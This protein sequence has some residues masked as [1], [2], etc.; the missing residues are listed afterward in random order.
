MTQGKRKVQR[1]VDLSSYEARLVEKLHTD[2]KEMAKKRKAKIP[3]LQDV[4]AGAIRTGIHAV[5]GSDYLY[6]ELLS[7]ET[8][9]ELMV[10]GGEL[11]PKEDE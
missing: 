8:M 7:E 2:L 4:L 9:R 6:T 11:A 1:F 3:T 10:S 5:Y